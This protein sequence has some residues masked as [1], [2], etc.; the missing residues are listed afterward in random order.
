ML[1]PFVDASGM[2]V[3]LPAPPR[4]IV[5]LI[6]SITE[7]LFSLG[8]GDAV[9]A[10]T[11]F[12]TE[13]RDAVA[14]KPRIGGEKNPKLDMI[15]ELGA[16]L[17]VANIE[18]NLREH[19]EILRGWGIPVFVTY[20]RTVADGIE[21]VR[22]LGRVSGAVGRAEEIAAGLERQL[23]LTR[24]R[25]RAREPVRVFCPIWR[26]P[27]MT[28]NADTYIHDMLA[29][30]GGENVFAGRGTRYPEVGL[31]EV[32]D[33]RPDVILL[34]DEP[35]RFRRAH[36]ADFARCPAIPAVRDGRIHLVDGKLLSWYGPRIERALAMLPDL[37]TR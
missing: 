6:P 34:P 32:A 2:A 21:L 28:I 13:P 33:A 9:A 10:C 17:V 31:D 19:V 30:C 15:R 16:D 20:P 4:R 29:E 18:E 11:V 3:M 12:C 36:V 27:Y 26:K 5:S 8:L 35:Y 7:V 14:T 25:V 23:S 37:L 1:G 24:S 22:D